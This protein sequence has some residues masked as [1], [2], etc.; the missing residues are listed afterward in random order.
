MSIIMGVIN[1]F[2]IPKFL[3]TGQYAVLMTYSL[4]V[5]F[6]GVFPLGFIDGMYINYGGKDEKDIN[7]GI[8]K[9]EHRFLFLFQLLIAV[10]FLTVSI[11]LQ[12][13]VIFY[14][15][16][17][18]L[19]FTLIGFFKLF[20]QAVGNFDK[21][22]FLSILNT[23]VMF[24]F[25]MILILFGTKEAETF[26]IANVISYYITFIYIEY[27]YYLTYKKVNI[28]KDYTLIKNN[29]KIGA[30]ILVGNLSLLLF[31]S[32]D[33]WIVRILLDLESFAYYSFAISMMTLINVLISAITT[34]FYPYLS[35]NRE[36]S[37]LRKLKNY[38]L[39]IGS[40]A[41]ASYFVFSMIV[42]YFIPKYKPSLEIIAILL[43]SLPV[44]III[45]VLY[46]NLYQAQKRERLYVWTIVVMLVV[47]VVMNIISVI[48]Q[49]SNTSIALA[50]TVSFYIWYY[51]SSRHFKSLS[52]SSREILYLLLFNVLYVLL[53]GVNNNIWLGALLFMIGLSF[54]IYVFFKDDIRS[55][56]IDALKA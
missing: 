24:V 3:G 51:Y 27:I 28:R 9:F 33:R 8:F 5:S 55:L 48:L 23:L 19:P 31:Y 16:L 26:M 46:V 45:K 43:A 44:M 21:F 15:S 2:V 10:I 41:S 4:F 39:I 13:R 36:D 7:K 1:G 11:V 50:T 35:K 47:S 52:I 40:C 49:K 32:I 29:F 20:Y 38:F 54:L 22:T 14:F 37:M 56:F 25:N 18:I 17:T 12:N 6:I 34:T 42:I 53:V 30:P